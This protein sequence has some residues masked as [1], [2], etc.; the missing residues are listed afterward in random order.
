LSKNIAII[1]GGIIG[2]L[3]A[4]KLRESGFSVVIVDKNEIGKESS[5]AGAG[6][7][8]PLMPWLY[9]AEVYNL[10][11]NS[12]EF[13]EEFSR[14]LFRDT[15][16]DPEFN[17]SGIK[18]IPPHSKNNIYQWARN[19]DYKIQNS[20]FQKSSAI[21]FPS[22][23]QIRPPRLMKAIRLYLSQ[24]GINVIENT[25]L[26]PIRAE[27]KT[28]NKWPTKDGNSIE[29]DYF[30]VTSGAW[31]SMIQAKYQKKIYPV[32]GQMIQYKASSL[33]INHILYS[34][35]FYILQRK[36]GVIIAGSTAEEVGFD[37]NVEPG[38]I[39][40]LKK[41]AEQLI[42][43][44][45][46]ILVENHWAGFRPGSKENIPIIGKDDNFENLYINSG[47]FRYGITMAPKSAEIINNLLVE[48]RI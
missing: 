23:A 19:H 44:L 38:S 1:G 34:D 26:C 10:C 18:L 13:Y 9:S 31:T 43:G 35:D 5:W 42:P 48:S 22:V 32:R 8:F 24:V 4:I 28:L 37:A 15:G 27:K 33:K 12:S 16:I 40:Y 47:H 3:S 20:T 25:E 14:K 21:L 36:D 11:L 45:K 17:R 46:N 39:D 6:I 41:K 2:C 30:I 7:L 29:A